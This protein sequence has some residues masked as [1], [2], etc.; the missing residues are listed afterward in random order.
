MRHPPYRHG[1]LILLCRQRLGTR[2]R[3]KCHCRRRTSCCRKRNLHRPR[4]RNR[5]IRRHSRT[6]LHH[7]LIYH[8]SN[9]LLQII[10]GNRIDRASAP[11]RRLPLHKSTR[12][13]RKRTIG[14]NLRP[15]TPPHQRTLDIAAPH[16]QIKPRCRPG[17]DL[18]PSPLRKPLRVEYLARIRSIRR[19]RVRQPKHLSA[20]TRCHQ[21]TI[22]RRGERHCLRSFQVRNISKTPRLVR[23]DSIDPSTIPRRGQQTAIPHRQR[24]HHVVLQRHQLLRRTIHRNLVNLRPIRHQRIRPRRGRRPRL[25]KRNR[26]PNIS[27]YR[28]RWKCGM[29]LR[30]H[31]GCINTARSIDRQRRYLAPSRRIHRKRLCPRGPRRKLVNNTRPI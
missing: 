11:Q 12:R 8:R 10:Q 26:H 29:P 22:L 3:R 1:C 14:S 6:R 25:Y 18:H 19:N 16:K 5:R 28:Q 17:P 21:Q 13:N 7:N 15:L 20:I 27:R 31:T 9:I 23:I 30:P 2:I 4:I 24:I